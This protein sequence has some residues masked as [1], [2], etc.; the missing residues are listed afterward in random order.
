MKVTLV[1]ALTL[2][3]KIGKTP[4]H[5]PDWT[6]K[7]DKKFFAALSRKAGVVI[8]GSKT[9][10]TFGTPLPGRVNVVMTRDSS[11]VSRD[12]NLW[13]TQEGPEEILRTLEQQGYSE[14]VLAGGSLV[15]T[16]F[17]RE[18]FIDEIIVTISPVIFGR[19]V[20]LF[21]DDVSLILKLQAME[22][23]GEDLVCLKYT[24]IKEA[25]RWRS[26]L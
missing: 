17:A 8:M 6:G 12:S 26:P 23:I 20:S 25:N 19:G 16:L 24:V 2:D 7:E 10:D 5:F 4:D 11:R 22:R 15:N 18:G 3:G 1:M 13:F 21:S 9:F 14:V